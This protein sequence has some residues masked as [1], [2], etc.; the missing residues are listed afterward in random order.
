M[1][2]IVLQRIAESPSSFSDSRWYKTIEESINALGLTIE[3]INL[4]DDKQSISYIAQKIF[5]NP[6]A[7]AFKN[8][9][10]LGEE[11]VED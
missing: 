1:L 8:I 5:D 6:L 9:E 3:S 2:Q 10:A 7:R 4:Q 11:D